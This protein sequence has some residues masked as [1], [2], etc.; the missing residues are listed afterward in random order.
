VR[1]SSAE[2]NITLRLWGRSTGTLITAAVVIIGDL[3]LA[4]RMVISRAT[5]GD[6]ADGID[7]TDGMDHTDIGAAITEIIGATVVMDTDPA[8]IT[9]AEVG[10]AEDEGVEEVVIDK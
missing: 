4:G 9:G 3:D 7:R 1:E 10:T 8:V 6:T 2:F 5:M